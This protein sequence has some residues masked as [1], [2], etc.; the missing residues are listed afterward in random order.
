MKIELMMK[1]APSMSSRAAA[2]M[3]TACAEVTGDSVRYVNAAGIR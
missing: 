1:A 2:M 3:K